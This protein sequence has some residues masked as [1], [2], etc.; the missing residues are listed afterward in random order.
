LSIV[1]CSFR[2]VSATGLLL[3]LLLPPPPPPPHTPPLLLGLLE[4]RSA[5][6]TTS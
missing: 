6:R 1:T 3:L 5:A 4:S 2:F